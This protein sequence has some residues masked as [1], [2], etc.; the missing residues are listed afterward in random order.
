MKQGQI[1]GYVGRTGLATGDHLHY[2]F[3][4]NGR[5]HNPVT[6]KLPRS[7]PIHDKQR[8]KFKYHAKNM[9]E[10]LDTHFRK[11]ELVIA[12]QDK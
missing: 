4:I 3:R 1:I 12:K 7:L 9:V 2:E 8:K 6:V 10:L 5:H 11:S